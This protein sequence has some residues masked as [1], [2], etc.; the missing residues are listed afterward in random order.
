[1]DV[2]RQLALPSRNEASQSYR[3]LP[4]REV[5]SASSQVFGRDTSTNSNRNLS[6]VGQGRKDRAHP[7]KRVANSS[8]Q[9]RRVRAIV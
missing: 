7:S 8:A 5:R 6:R 3:H 4:V 2:R 1:M 9:E